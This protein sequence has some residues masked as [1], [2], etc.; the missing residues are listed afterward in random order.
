[1]TIDTAIAR[2]RRRQQDV[3][4]DTATVTRSST[5]EA[6]LNPTT[7]VLEVAS[8]SEVYSG[9]CLIRPALTWEGRDDRYGGQLVHSRR[10]RAKFPVGTDIQI[11]DIVIPDTSTHDDSLEG[12]AFRVSDLFPDDWQICRNCLLVRVEDS[13]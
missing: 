2:F 4:R 1:M 10:L 3:F 13:L 8:P 12:V 9:P 5:S 11:N 6:T 7:N